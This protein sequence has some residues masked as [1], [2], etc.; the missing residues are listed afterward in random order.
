[1][2][3][4]LVLGGHWA[5]RI[6]RRKLELSFQWGVNLLIGPNGSG[7]STI[8]ECL[9]TEMLSKE[10]L[11]K[12]Q[13]AAQWKIKGQPLRV[14]NFDFETDNPRINKGGIMDLADMRRMQMHF[15][16][17]RSS[18]GEITRRILTELD[19]KLEGSRGFFVMLDEPEQALD[20]TGL[21]LLHQILVAKR[22]KWHQFIIST[23]HPY[24]ITEP[25]FSVIE[26][27]KGYRAKTIQ[28]VQEMARR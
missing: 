7:K 5:G 12:R 9:R 8:L 17:S 22:R 10:P 21:Q 6:K 19:T 15:A 27:S 28:A 2:L 16:A 24:L 23:H 20:L 11:G 18:H 4:T 1:M 26:L 25:K 13:R 3:Q 14:L